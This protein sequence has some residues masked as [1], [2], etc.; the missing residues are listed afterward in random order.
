MN[1]YYLHRNMTGSPVHI[2]NCSRIN[3]L[4]LSVH[5]GVPFVP[6]SII[7]CFTP[8]GH[9]QIALVRYLKWLMEGEVKWKP[10]KHILREAVRSN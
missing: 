4:P 10:R 2:V 6:Y 1:A 3:D 5:F 8:Y 9:A 7:V